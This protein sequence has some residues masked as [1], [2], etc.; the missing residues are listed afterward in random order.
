ME[1]VDENNEL[2]GET[3]EDAIFREVKEELGIEIS[4]E[5]IQV[6]ECWKGNDKSKISVLL[7]TLFLL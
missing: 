7:T 3:V 4:K 2:T 1:L 6:L 5:Q